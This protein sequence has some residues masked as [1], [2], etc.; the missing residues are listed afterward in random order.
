MKG[1]RELARTVAN[2]VSRGN[3]P[4]A[5]RRQARD[6]GKAPLD[7]ELF[8][9]VLQ[10]FIEKH[11]EKPSKTL[12]SGEEIKRMLNSE[13]LPVWRDRTIKSIT[14]ADVSDLVEG[15]RA[16][17]ADVMANRV[18]AAIRK[19]FNWASAPT[20]GIIS[21]SPCGGVEVTPEISRD[22][23]NRI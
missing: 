7:K 16:R 23:T 19:L 4:V 22:R 1:A 15:I 18:F 3:N 9:N 6:S 14:T 13:V 21:V 11:V 20:R 17:G 8:K 12:R 10:L 2:K 5:E